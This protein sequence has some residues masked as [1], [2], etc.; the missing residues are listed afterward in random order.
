MCNHAAR[1]H[2]NMA[3]S[4]NLPYS[5]S[6][7]SLAKPYSVPNRIVTTT[8]STRSPHTLQ[9][10]I[11][12]SGKPGIWGKACSL[13]GGYEELCEQYRY[14]LVTRTCFSQVTFL[15]LEAADR[16]SAVHVS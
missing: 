11:A 1:A 16:F 4:L 12:N 15:S 7:I 2:Q 8:Y 3:V 10:K 14:L 6:E 5:F 9:T 13:R